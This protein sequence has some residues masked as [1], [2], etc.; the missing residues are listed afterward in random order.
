MRS[1]ATTNLRIEGP[2]EMLAEIEKRTWDV[3]LREVNGE[4]YVTLPARDPGPSFS[5][6]GRPDVK[7]SRQ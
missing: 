5:M 7:L 2:R 3:T 4:Q 1:L 6:E